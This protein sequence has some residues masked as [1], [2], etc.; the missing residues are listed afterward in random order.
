[1]TKALESLSFLSLP[2]PSLKTFCDP[3]L[4]STAVEPY[5]MIRF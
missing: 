5:I 2:I 1:M 3:S 4:R